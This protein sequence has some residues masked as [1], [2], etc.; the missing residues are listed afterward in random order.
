MSDAPPAEFAEG[1]EFQVDEAFMGGLEKNKHSL[2]KIPGGQGGATK[3][4]VICITH[5]N[6]GKIWAD[7]IADTKAKTI[8]DIVHRI[9]PDDG[10]V[11]Y[12]DKAGHYEGVKRERHAV[13]HKA[14]EYARIV[15]LADGL[16][17]EAT[18]NYTE[19]A[20]SILKRSFMGVYHKIST[21][22]LRRYV[23]TFTGRWNIRDLGTENQSLSRRI[24]DLMAPHRSSQPWIPFCAVFQTFLPLP[25]YVS[26][27]TFWNVATL[28]RSD[29]LG[30]RGKVSL[31]PKNSTG[32][33]TK[34]GTCQ[35]QTERTSK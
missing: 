1:G 17:G 25:K 29:Y 2:D 13:N 12:T 9:V 35:T 7:V 16:Q 3:M 31:L 5:I 14:S 24:I 28:R 4:I 21:K 30:L 34:F 26:C 8:E 15:D 18:T 10:T 33:S 20:W 23:K 22:H 27:P 11:I 6:S 32:A 19:S